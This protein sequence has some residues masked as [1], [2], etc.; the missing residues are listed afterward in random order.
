MDEEIKRVVRNARDKNQ[1]R[2]AAQ[3]LLNQDP[4]RYAWAQSY[5]N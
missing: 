5:L 2:E 4:V 1:Q 3:Y